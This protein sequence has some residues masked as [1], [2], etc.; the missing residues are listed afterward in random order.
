MGCLSGQFLLDIPLT[1]LLCLARA[2]AILSNRSVTDHCSKRRIE[3][4]MNGKSYSVALATAGCIGLFF[5]ITLLRFEAR[6]QAPVIIVQPQSQ[7]MAAT[8]NMPLPQF[9]VTAGGGSPLGYQ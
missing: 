4:A 6:A 8:Y 5:S 3:A 1:Y 2:I 7:T 9:T